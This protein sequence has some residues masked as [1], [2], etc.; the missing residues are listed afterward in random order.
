VKTGYD[1]TLAHKVEAGADIFLMPSKWEPCGLNQF[2]SLKYGT[3]PVVHAT[4]G[5]DD[6]IEEW[7]GKGRKGT[8][9]KFGEYA[10]EAF[11]EAIRRALRAFR[12]K[13]A[14]QALMRNG[15]AKDFSWARPAAQYVEAYERVVRAR[16]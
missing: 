4:G 1:D 15:M 8:G 16:S 7:D 13:D 10:P 9:F 6:T 14:W 11:L 3:P 2:Y 5:L 12:D